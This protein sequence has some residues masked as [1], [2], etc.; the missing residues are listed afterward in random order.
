MQNLK[1]ISFSSLIIIS[2]SISRLLVVAFEE[3]ENKVGKCSFVLMESCGL[4]RI[5]NQLNAA[6]N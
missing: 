4:S 2:G 5:Y 3:S 1:G 6:K